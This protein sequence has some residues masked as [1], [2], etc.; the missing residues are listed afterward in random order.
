MVLRE[1]LAN[2]RFALVRWVVRLGVLIR[3]GPAPKL[4]RGQIVIYQFRALIGHRCLGILEA[5]VLIKQRV[6]GPVLEH[7]IHRLNQLRLGPPIGAQRG[8]ALGGLLSGQ[9]AEHI[10]AAKAV[11]R[12]LRVAN[13][14]K[15][16]VAVLENIEKNFALQRIRVLKLINQRCGELPANLFA[17]R[18]AAFR[19]QRIGQFRD[20]V[21]IAHHAFGRLQLA[22]AQLCMPDKFHAQ[23]LP[24][25]LRSGPCLS[26]QIKEP[27]HRAVCDFIQFF[28]VR[29]RDAVPD[30]FPRELFQVR[31]LARG[32]NATGNG[33]HALQ[34]NGNNGFNLIPLPGILT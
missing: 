10:R 19:P 4:Q 30:V 8:L 14:K 27:P 23:R 2:P 5:D 11:N 31:K 28:S 32:K 1:S 6:I 13:Q 21:A 29:R 15:R 26:T 20:Q 25:S 9:I 18:I 3:A 7:R 33:R 22:Q 17:Q 24:V 12:L 34:Q 16:S